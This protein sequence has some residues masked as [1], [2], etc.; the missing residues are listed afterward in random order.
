MAAPRS[1]RTTVAPRQRKSSAIAKSSCSRSSN[2]ARHSDLPALA[3]EFGL[4]LGEI[5]EFTRA[6]A[7]PLGG[8]PEL[9][10]AVF[11]EEA[12][13]GNRI[14]GPVALAEDRL[15][16]FKVPRAS[17]ADAAAARERAR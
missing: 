10:Q 2:R 9:A 4:Q 8:K 16:I 15:V 6:G 12:L 11:S 13:A 17:R 14:G 1:R 3:S 5:Q 7:A